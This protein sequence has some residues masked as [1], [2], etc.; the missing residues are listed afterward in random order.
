M[1]EMSVLFLILFSNIQQIYYH[2]IVNNIKECAFKIL[3]SSSAFIIY[4]NLRCYYCSML[5]TTGII[6][7]TL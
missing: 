3:K 4:K 1:L 6:S 5:D 7:D 2:K